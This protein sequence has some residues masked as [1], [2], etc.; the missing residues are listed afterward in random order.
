MFIDLHV[1]QT[2]PYSN[3]NRD[4]VGAPK[5][6]IYGGTQRIRVSSQCW[7]R[8]TREDMEQAL[9]AGGPHDQALRTRAPFTVLGK[10][11]VGRGWSVEEADH[12]ARVAFREYLKEEKKAAEDDESP[13]A[14]AS[15]VLLFLTESQYDDIATV[16]EAAKSLVL[17]SKTADKKDPAGPDFKAFRKNVEAILKESRGVVSVFG[18]M[19]A[20]LPSANVESATQVAHA[21]TVHEASSEYDYFTAVDDYTKDDST[22]AGHLG[23]NEFATGTFYRY[24]TVDLEALRENAGN[25]ALA[26]SLAAHF[27]EAFLTSV[28]SGKISGTAQNVRPNII[29]VSLRKAPLSYAAAFENPVRNQ[30]SGYLLAATHRLVGHADLIADAYDDVPL[31]SGHLNAVDAELETALTKAFGSKG[32][33]AELISGALT[34]AG[35]GETAIVAA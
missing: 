12:A 15:S 14:A 11:L 9:T 3:L 10:I 34:A 22:G 5:S 25:D 7:K 18:R 2:F 1:L 28:P 29:V 35:L 17:A 23:T 4:D 24:A 26:A 13:A 32:R 16:I 20:S 30:D 33:I 31:W 27:C 19:I 6:T 21:F 8:V